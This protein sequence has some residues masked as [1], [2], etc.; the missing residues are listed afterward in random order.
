MNCPKCDVEMI[1]IDTGIEFMHVCPVCGLPADCVDF[2]DDDDDDGFRDPRAKYD[3]LRSF[4][5][6]FTFGDLDNLA[7]LL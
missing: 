1:L 7:S 5:A 4:D 3:D 6:Q 2:S